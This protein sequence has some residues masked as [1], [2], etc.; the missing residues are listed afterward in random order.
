MIR[1][2]SEQ[3]VEFF[4]NGEVVKSVDIY[5][6]RPNNKV[7]R[8]ADMLRSKTWSDCTAQGIPTKKQVLEM[9]IEKGEWDKEKQLL[10]SQLGLE[11]VELER[12][13][14]IGEEGKKPKLSEGRE[15]AIQIRQKRY[16]LRTL[17]SQKIS[18]EEN[19]AENLA[20]NARFDYLVAKCSF[21]KDGKPIYSS[22]DE[23]NEKSA[24]ELAYAAASLLGKMMYNIDSNFE[25]NLPEN[26]F[27]KKFGLINDDL[28]LI[29]PNTG[30]TIDIEGKRIDENGFYVDEEGNRIDA[31][32][33]RI[34]E[35]GFYEMVEYENDL[36]VKPK[37][38][39]KTTKKTT[40]KTTTEKKPTES[41]TG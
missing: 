20:D 40:T 36:V 41:T 37:P 14:Y 10:E 19:S 39:R 5:V 21:Y 31:D 34:T 16:Q 2:K 9:M 25:A 8:E 6:T 38:K 26:K 12:K 24:D 22:F 32:G 11:I 7:N 18:L 17:I 15:L 13:L 1:N 28:S 27:L 23:Y 33:N 35:D 4:E 29:D 30:H 3:T